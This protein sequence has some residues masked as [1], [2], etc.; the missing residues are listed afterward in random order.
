MIAERGKKRRG[1]VCAVWSTGAA[2]ALGGLALVVVACGSSS[3]TTPTTAQGLW[4]PN[5]SS[6]ISE[7]TGSALTASD[8]P[9]PDVTNLSADLNEPVG[10]A[11]D[12]SNNLWASNFGS[13]TL[14]E[15][16][17]A[18]LKALA[19]TN[20]PAASVVI[21]GL[22][23]PRGLAFDASANLWAANFR[24][25]TLVEFTPSQLAAG[26]PQTPH[27]TITSTDVSEPAG[28]AF[29]ESG[30]LWVANEPNNTLVLFAASQ[31]S[32]GGS[33]TPTVILSSNGTGSLD[34]PRGIGFDGAGNLWVANYVDATS[35][36][37]TV[38]E[39]AAADLG[40]SGSPNPAVTISS[41][42]VNTSDS[43]DGPRGVA[44]DRHGNLWVG[45][46]FSD[47]FGSLAEFAKGQ[48]TSSGSPTPKVFLDSNAAG[49]NINQPELFAF[50]PSI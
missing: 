46:F 47:Q 30:G 18:Q 50:V 3:N 25:S 10:I 13:G 27:V 6:S 14:T 48:L 36:L 7:F 42:T 21:S 15:F 5:L 38:V 40:T 20:N 8:T 49:S 43:L 28:I 44:F 29:T 11:F 34:R 45:N 39:F 22:D 41:T 23:E 26:G 33:Q 37:G 9:T 12:K 24:N 16:T 17:L 31:L 32:A 2:A 35:D 1:V 19:T 4:V